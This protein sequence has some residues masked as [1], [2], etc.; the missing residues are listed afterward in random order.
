MDCL[1]TDEKLAVLV[2]ALGQGCVSVLAL[3]GNQISNIGAR[4]LGEALAALAPLREL[5][6]N[7]NCI[8]DP[9]V[10]ALC[11]GPVRPPHGRRE[12]GK[13][14]QSE[15][16]AAHGLGEGQKVECQRQVLR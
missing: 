16:V 1:I 14:A 4:T 10:E 11:K 2:A 7:G 5:H 9:G 13:V 15:A 3:G 6:L 12:E 8:A